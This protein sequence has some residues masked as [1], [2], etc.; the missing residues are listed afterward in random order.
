MPEHAE[1]GAGGYTPKVGDRIRIDTGY[2]GH[3]DGIVRSSWPDLREGYA[4]LDRKGKCPTC[5][6]PTPRGRRFRY[7]E[8]THIGSSSST[9]KET[10]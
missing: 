3:E 5:E 9:G 2:G 10:D 1:F 7:D 8:A 4:E 6:Q